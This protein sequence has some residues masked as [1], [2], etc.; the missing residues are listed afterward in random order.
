[1]EAVNLKCPAKIN[2]SLD[3]VGERRD[4]Y[5]LLRTIMQSVS[6]YD[7]VEIKK[8]KSGINIECDIKDIPIDE[9]NT[10]YK[11]AKLMID[12]FSLDFGFDISIHKN[13]PYAAGLAG[14]SA[15]AA[16]VIKGISKL[17]NL[18][19]NLDD[20]KSIG[21]KVGAD[22]PYCLIGGT[23]LSEGIGEIITPLKEIPLTYF[24]IAKPDLFVSTME[25]FKKLRMD[26]I[27]RHPDTDKL[28][29]YI[30]DGNIKLL[31]EDMAN[32]LETVTI[33]EHPIIFEIKKIMRD[34]DALGSIMSGSGPSV[35][36]VFDNM[37]LAEKC[38]HRL[39]DYLKDVFLVS[40]VS[41]E[42]LQAI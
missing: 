34:F 6:L 33:K 18:N 2:L 25:V 8:N 38:Y 17:M 11:A 21:L 27:P 41:Q 7:E 20:M 37:P 16:G 13:I 36:G 9:K 4:G 3:V 1:M 15:D 10:A 29:K 5:H 39:R 30:E 24:V 40:S 28:I 35:F 26:E 12:E 19:L 23:A 42:Y 32:V 14:G 31:S 22:V